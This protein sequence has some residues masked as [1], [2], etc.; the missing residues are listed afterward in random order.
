MRRLRPY[1]LL[2]C[3]LG[4]DAAVFAANASVGAQIV[5]NTLNGFREMLGVLPPI[6]LLLGLL[7]VWV[8][9]ETIIRFLGERSGA[10]GVALSIFLGAA[11]AGPLYGAFPV[12]QVMMKKGA[13]F[14]NVLIFL[15]SWSTL[16]IPMFLFEISSLGYKFA[17]TRWI[18]NVIGIILMALAIDRLVTPAEKAQ[19]FERQAAFR[20]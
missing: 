5:G 8:P 11:A 13:S 17:L 15:G 4:I 9:R 16:K 10:L 14:T 12:A 3:V 19:V 18:V 7:D 1:W 2:I 6:F 20:D